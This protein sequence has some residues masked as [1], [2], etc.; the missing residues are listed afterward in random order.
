MVEIRY[1]LFEDFEILICVSVLEVKLDKVM[2]FV[3]LKF[4]VIV[5]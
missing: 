5:G 3:I 1:L 2:L 4:I